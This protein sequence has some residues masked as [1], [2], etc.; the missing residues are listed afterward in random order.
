ME[1]PHR[2]SKEERIELVTRLL[3]FAADEAA[4]LDEKYRTFAISNQ[5][6]SIRL[7]AGYAN[8][9][10]GDLSVP[11]VALGDWNDASVQMLRGGRYE[12][13]RVSALPV[14][15]ERMLRRYGVGVEWHDEWATCE[16]CDKAVRTQPDCMVWE[17][18]YKVLEGELLCFP[19]LEEKA[20][21]DAKDA[22]DDD[23]DE[24]SCALEHAEP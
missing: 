17:A 14:R 19:C 20:K 9:Y 24:D 3:A 4:R 6:D 5:I 15:V 11:L 1:V 7:L 13:E 12:Y 10:D 22:E 23:G 16:G 18:K 2:I 8:A 21:E